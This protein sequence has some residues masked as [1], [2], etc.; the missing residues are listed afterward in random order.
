MTTYATPA[1]HTRAV[2]PTGIA[3]AVIASTLSTLFAHDWGEVVVVV[4]VIGVTTGVVFGLVVPRA[5]RKPSAGGTA[6]GLALPAAVLLLPAFWSGLP[7]VLGLAGAIVGNAG[8]NAET[9]SG[10]STAALVISALVVLCYLS[11]YVAEGIAG[12]TGFLLS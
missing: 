1:T 4:A 7:F 3:A 8:R 10:K 2:V 6:L 5:L 9:G 12:H 11:I